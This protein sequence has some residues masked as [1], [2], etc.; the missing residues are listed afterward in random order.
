MSS[1]LFHSPS[2]AEVTSNENVPRISSNNI[3]TSEEMSLDLKQYKMREDEV[4]NRI[5]SN[6]LQGLGGVSYPND[7]RGSLDQRNHFGWPGIL[8][9]LDHSVESSPNSI[10]QHRNMYLSCTSSNNNNIE[11]RQFAPTIISSIQTP[12]SLSRVRRAFSDG[13]KTEITRNEQRSSFQNMDLPPLLTYSHVS[14]S[15]SQ[16]GHYDPDE[17]N[18]MENLSPLTTPTVSECSFDVGLFD[19]DD[20]EYENTSGDFDNIPGFE[21]DEEIN[22]VEDEKED[23]SLSGSTFTEIDNG[24]NLLECSRIHNGSLDTNLKHPP[25]YRLSS[26]RDVDAYLIDHFQNNIGSDY[27]NNL[28]RKNLTHEFLNT[29][30]SPH[31]PRN[32]TVINNDFFEGL[33]NNGIVN[34]SNELDSSNNET[35]NINRKREVARNGQQN[36]GSFSAASQINGTFPMDNFVRLDKHYGPFR[37]DIKHPNFFFSPSET[38]FNKTYGNTSLTPQT[39]GIL[40]NDSGSHLSG[41]DDSSIVNYLIYKFPDDEKAKFLTPGSLEYTSTIDFYGNRG[42]EQLYTPGLTEKGVNPIEHSKINPNTPPSDRLLLNNLQ[43]VPLRSR[44]I[45]YS[46]INKTSRIKEDKKRKTTSLIQKSVTF[47]S[48]SSSFSTSSSMNNKNFAMNS[49][50]ASSKSNFNIHHEGSVNEE[51]CGSLK[52]HFSHQAFA[53]INYQSLNQKR[54]KRKY[55]Q[56]SF[57][58]NF[59]DMFTTKTRIYG[60]DEED[61]KI[62]SDDLEKRGKRRKPNR[63]NNNHPQKRSIFERGHL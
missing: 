31:T 50:I 26:K 46:D 1:F 22:Y 27:S 20:Q 47:S 35:L 24:S 45:D 57:N 58:K 37:D 34:N 41:E 63:P 2:G 55:Q 52:S 9:G 39:Q 32:S 12:T 15:K 62:D 44:Y 28:S 16:G 42:G 6:S 18:H 48:D 8:K 21:N 59:T 40:N 7:E 4:R 19:H 56:H 30:T 13:S 17:A 53:G 36:L 33:L 14:M 10:V 23:D 61:E 11:N 43:N 49:N 54:R 38:N 51:Q 29:T 5:Q 3:V 25:Y 60:S